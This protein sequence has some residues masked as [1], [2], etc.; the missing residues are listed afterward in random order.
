MFQPISDV[1]TCQIE[2]D[3]RSSHSLGAELKLEVLLL[4]IPLS[5]QLPCCIEYSV[6][7]ASFDLDIQMSFTWPGYVTLSLYVK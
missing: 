7:C 5:V 4:E 1:N 6:I 3:Y 2:A